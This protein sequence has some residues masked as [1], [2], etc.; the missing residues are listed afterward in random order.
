[1]KHS[2]DM[3]K[4]LSQGEMELSVEEWSLDLEVRR[5]LPS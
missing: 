4:S 3:G 5:W 1:M 2:R